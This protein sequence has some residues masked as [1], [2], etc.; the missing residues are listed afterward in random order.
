MHCYSLWQKTLI[1]SIIEVRYSIH[2]R[3]ALIFPVISGYSFFPVTVVNNKLSILKCHHFKLYV[4]QK[5][6]F[7]SQIN[8]VKL[9]FSTKFT[10]FH[11]NA[12]WKFKPLIREALKTNAITNRRFSGILWLRFVAYSFSSILL[13]F[14]HHYFSICRHHSLVMHKVSNLTKMDAYRSK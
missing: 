11:L 12:N 3:R 10:R 1:N 2:H 9:V 14:Q 4:L 6:A 7:L 5:N 13:M 8:A